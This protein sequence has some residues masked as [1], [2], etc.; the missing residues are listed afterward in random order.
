[1][2]GMR[3]TGRVLGLLLCCALAA[4]VYAATP[5]DTAQRNAASKWL[6]GLSP[7]QRK[8]AAFAFDD[9][10]R[11]NWAYV[12]RARKGLP[13]AQMNDA[14]RALTMELLHSALSDKGFAKVDG[15]FKLESL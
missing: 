12:P 7:E 15:V 11:K 2:P 14:Q 3:A 8:Q 6:A 5:P 10:E 4:F 13:L 1:M 9:D